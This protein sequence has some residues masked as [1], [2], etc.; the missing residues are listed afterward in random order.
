M[1]FLSTIVASEIV[2]GEYSKGTF[3]LYL[4]R[5]ATRT[6]VL[7]SKLVVVYIYTTSIMVFFYSYT[8]L[9]SLFVLGLGDLAVFHNGLLFLD[10]TDILW[11]FIL[12]LIIS[13]GVMI[14]ISS[15]CFLFS[16][17]SNNSVTPIIS[18][19]SIV[20]IGTAISFIPIEVFEN[21]NPLLFTGYIDL[22][23]TAFY[24]P[25]PTE[26]IMNC[27]IINIIWCFLFIS[28]SFYFF[29]KKDILD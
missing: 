28:L 21:I 18:T 15:L 11:R 6:Q 25:V 2:S 14:T 23:L 19:I 9:L 29:N 10:E 13:N 5:P 22:F 3:R 4:T 20:F 16:S 27:F 7:L 8:L 26:K 24:D 12:A 17:I 1:P